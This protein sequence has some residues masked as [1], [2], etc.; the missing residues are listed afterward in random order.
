MYLPW[1]PFQA[2]LSITMCGFFI[3]MRYKVL[4]SYL[5]VVYDQLVPETNYPA[6]ALVNKRLSFR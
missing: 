1:P 4:V 3:Y 5:R 2:G 6:S